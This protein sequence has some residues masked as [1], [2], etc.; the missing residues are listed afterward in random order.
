[1]DGYISIE[2][3][4][5]LYEQP[6]INSLNKLIMADATA[7]GLPSPVIEN[8]I[9]KE[10]LPYYSNTHS[11]A[12]C[13]NLMN[14]L[15][16]DTRKYM[17]KIYNLNDNYVILFSGNGTTGAIN[18]LVNLID[19]KKYRRVN[20]IIS[21]Y[22]HYSNFLPWVKMCKINNNMNIFYLSLNDDGTINLDILQSFLRDNTNIEDLTIISITACS[23]VSGIKTNIKL[24]REIIDKNNIYGTIKL[25][26][27]YATL[28]PYEN[29]NGNLLDG[30]A[31]SGH[32]FSG[33]NGTPGVLII[34]K[35][36]IEKKEPFIIGGGVVNIATKNKINYKQNIEEREMG[37]TLNIIG[38]LKLKKALEL[39]NEYMNIIKNNEK[40]ITKY[41]HNKLTKLCQKYKKLHVLYLNKSL[42]NRL[43]IICIT[44]NNLHYNTIVSLLSDLYGIQ[45]RGGISCAGLFAEYIQNYGWCRIT[46]SWYMSINEIDFILN[47]IG[48]ILQNKK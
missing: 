14:K 15:I 36:I 10:I 24:I 42:D 17:R 46:F 45:T 7:T 38:I 16:E 23:N 21:L 27:D 39:Y 22:E 44:I 29:I 20:I 31:F 11:N 26:G 25:F 8:Y 37:G 4:K 6:Y 41:V 12:Y 30:F 19:Y 35:E 2:R 33:G 34:K 48:N 3:N 28:A 47:S 32:K 1:M 5:I 13:S 43:P 40:W 9:I 18:H